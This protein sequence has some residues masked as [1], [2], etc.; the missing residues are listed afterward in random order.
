MANNDYNLKFLRR[1][2]VEE[3]TTL[4]RNKIYSLM[5]ENKFPKS[6]AIA[7]KVVVWVKKE[8][9]DWIDTKIKSSLVEVA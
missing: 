1:P 8:V 6:I 9:E 5:K 7:P 2:K 3:M 4:S